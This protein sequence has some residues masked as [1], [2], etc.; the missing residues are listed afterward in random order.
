MLCTIGIN[1]IDVAAAKRMGMKN[2]VIHIWF[3]LGRTRMF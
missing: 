1:H 2:F 3:G